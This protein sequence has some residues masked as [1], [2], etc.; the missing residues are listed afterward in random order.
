MM[1]R[2]AVG[3]KASDEEL[4]QFLP[5]I[6]RE[7][8]DERNYVKKAV[9]WA[10]RQISKCNLFLNRKAIEVANELLS[11]DSKSARW[12]SSVILREL[13]SEAVHKRL[14]KRQ[15]KGEIP[16]K[17]Q[18]EALMTKHQIPNNN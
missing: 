15:R 14:L 17:S 6:K 1:T 16:S 2:L 11:D 10:L 5:L 3:S 12:I 13:T 4:E 8:T 7:A 9:N 18:E